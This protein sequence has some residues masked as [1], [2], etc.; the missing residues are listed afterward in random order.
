[1]DISETRGIPLFGIDVWEHAYY[2]NYQNKRRIILS[3]GGRSLTGTI[4]TTA[5]VN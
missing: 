4:L 5:M 3:P 2:L 1:M